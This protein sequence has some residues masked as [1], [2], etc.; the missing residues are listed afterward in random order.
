MAY[1]IADILIGWYDR[2][3]RDLPWRQTTDP[4]K[5]WISEI[6]LQQTRVAQGL[7]YYYRFTERFPDVRTLAD[8]PEDEVLRYWQGLGY[9][10]RARNIHAAAKDVMARF[11]G[12]FP[13][14]YEGVR[15]LKG[16]GDYTAAAIVSFA[17]GMAHAAV[18][19]NVYRWL[20]RLLNMDL[21]ID[22]GAGKKYFAELA[23][24]LLPPE[25]AAVFNQATMEFGALQCVPKSPDCTV[26]P[27]AERCLALGS[28]TVDVLPVKKGKTEVK[29]RWF[30][31]LVIKNKD[32]V[33]LGQRTGNDIWRNL[34]EY[35]LIETD[36]EVDFEELHG[37]EAFKALFDGVNKVELGQRIVMPKHVLSH[38]IIYATFYE[39]EVDGFSEEMRQRYIE[40]HAKESDRYAVS[41]LTELYRERG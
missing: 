31:Y 30:N 2:H 37:S 4:Y 5:I 35:P 20:S 40:I 28:G 18:D 15:S 34:Y 25:R 22:S 16:V 7:E 14:T 13:N 41:R 36:Q 29:S 11:N 23:Q 6:I 9:Y 27:F 24:S 17:Y 32:R 10:S 3:H 38:R 26:C 33:L 8:A 12:E 21:P 19:G 39:F 1:E